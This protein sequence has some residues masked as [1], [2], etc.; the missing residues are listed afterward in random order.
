[1]APAA[2][3]IESRRSRARVRPDGD[4]VRIPTILGVDWPG[5]LA[6]RNATHLNRPPGI[7]LA[8]DAKACA[9]R[10][11]RQRALPKR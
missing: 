10:G 11:R 2:L 4:H 3:A 1:V 8:V 9:G 5:G 6:R 7:V